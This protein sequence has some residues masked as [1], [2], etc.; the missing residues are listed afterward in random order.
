VAV[1]HDV[2]LMDAETIHCVTHRRLACAY[3]PVRI[4][5]ILSFRNFQ[6]VCNRV[7]DVSLLSTTRARHEDA[8]ARGTI[9][10]DALPSH[11]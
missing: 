2:S 8:R 5:Q 9:R 7:T 10:G 4:L 3:H 11:H 6:V 1:N